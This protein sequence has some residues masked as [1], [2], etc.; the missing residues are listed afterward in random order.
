MR[1]SIDVELVLMPELNQQR[2]NQV[3]DISITQYLTTEGLV[4]A[5]KNIGNRKDLIE[6]LGGRVISEEEF[7]EIKQP[8]LDF[9]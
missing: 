7:I 5:I 1:I 8:P 3:E 2:S 9:Y 6:A 4:Y